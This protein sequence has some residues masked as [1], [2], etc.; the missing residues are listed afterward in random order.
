ML[1]LALV[2]VHFQDVTV[3]AVESFVDI[4]DG[5]HVVIALGHFRQAV[6]RIALGGFVNLGSLARSKTVDIDAKELLGIESLADLQARLFIVLGRDHEEK[7][8][9]KRCRAQRRG[10]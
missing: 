7:A 10:K 5:L 3:V 9:I 1:A 6:A 2:H 8:A 4:D